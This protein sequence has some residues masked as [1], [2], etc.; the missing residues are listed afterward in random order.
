MQALIAA[1]ELFAGGSDHVTAGE[2]VGLTDDQSRSSR[3]RAGRR[4]Y[5][6]ADTP[7]PASTPIA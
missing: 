5:R 1:L 2:L 4:F 6:A 7:D 3:A